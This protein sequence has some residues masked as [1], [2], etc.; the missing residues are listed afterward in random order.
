MRISCHIIGRR[1][2]Q[3]CTPSSSPVDIIDDSDII[4]HGRCVNITD[5]IIAYV[6]AGYMIPGAEIPVA[7]R[8]TIAAERNAYIH[9]W[10]YRRPAVVVTI[11]SPGNPGWG[12][13]ISRHPH[14][15][16]RIVIKPVSIVKGG[17]SPA[18]FRY[19]CPPFIRID[20]V[21]AR[22]IRPETITS[23][24]YPYISI[25]GIAYPGSIGT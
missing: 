12:P 14:P 1:P 23:S 18:V 2:P 15:A 9:A 17:P 6:D 24:G 4:D 8:W 3:I 20:P 13:F 11:L 5:I 7:D 16:I 10:P 21:P 22:T 19:P 25:I